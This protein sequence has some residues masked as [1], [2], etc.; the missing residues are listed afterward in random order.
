MKEKRF[1]EDSPEDSDI[2]QV[3]VR[4]GDL[5]LLATDGVFDNLFVEEILGIIKSLTKYPQRTK[6]NAQA[7]AKTIC[8]AA[9]SRSKKSHVKT[10]FS[11]K[12]AQYIIDQKNKVK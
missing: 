5:L 1:C 6:S 7:I 2:Y 4:E 10:P 8:D 3:R 9:L 11:M 12:K